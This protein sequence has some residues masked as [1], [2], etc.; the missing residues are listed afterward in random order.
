MPLRSHES[1]DSR[2]SYIF[3]E[4]TILFPDVFIGAQ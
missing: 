3:L 4:S 2:K 1:G